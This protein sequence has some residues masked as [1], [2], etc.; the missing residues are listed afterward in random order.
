MSYEFNGL[1][2]SV[3]PNVYINRITLEQLNSQPLSNNKYDQAPHI[4]Q[5][6]TVLATAETNIPGYGAAQVAD[7]P[8]LL[9]TYGSYEDVLKVTFDLFL[10]IPS[11]DSDDFWSFLFDDDITKHLSINLLLFS[12][13]A[14]KDYYKK[15]MSGRTTYDYPSVVTVV[16]NLDA[17]V[18]D[19]WN[20]K[21]E[22]DFEYKSEKSI[23]THLMQPGKFLDGP[24]WDASQKLA[25]IR[26][27]Y[28]KTLPDGTVVYKIPIRMEAQLNGTSPAHLAAIAY[29]GFDATQLLSDETGAWNSGEALVP[30]NPAQAVGQK[31][32]TKTHGRMA[33][34]VIIQN[35]K[36][37]D[38]GMIFFVSNDQS[39]YD[40]PEL[41]ATRDAMFNHLKGQLWF[42]NVRKPDK[43]V[44]DQTYNKTLKYLAGQSHVSDEEQ[45][46]GLVYNRPQPFLDYIVVPNHRIQDFRQTI[47]M[48][49]MANFNPAIESI[50]GGSY[51]DSRSTTKVAGLDRPAIFSNLISSIDNLNHIKLFFSIDWGKLIRKHCAVPALIDKLSFNPSELSTVFDMSPKPISFKVFRERVDV[52][53]SIVNDGGRKL[54]YD[55]YPN[56][57]FHVGEQNQTGD[58]PSTYAGGKWWPDVV[59]SSLTPVKINSGFNGRIKHYSFTDYDIKRTTKGKFK[60]SIEFELYDPT[61]YYLQDQL[62][63]IQIALSLLKKYMYLANGTHGNQLYYN[64]HLGYFEEGFKTLA[65]PGTPEIEGLGFTNGV[66]P[67]SISD[68]IGT[69]KFMTQVM[70]SK[71]SSKPSQLPVWDVTIKNMLNPD[72]ATPDSITTVYE[73][74]STIALQLKSFIQSFAIAKI[75]KAAT[76]KHVNEDGTTSPIMKSFTKVPTGPSIP[77]R[78]ITVE[79]TFDG[80]PEIVDT[81]KMTAAYDFFGDVK[82]LS[83]YNVG[84]KV[85]PIVG[86]GSGSSYEKKSISQ[87]SNYFLENELPGDADNIEKKAF[88]IPFE[89]GLNNTQHNIL[90]S[91]KET[92]GRFFTVSLNHTYLPKTIGTSMWWDKTLN[93]IIRYK[94]DLFGDPGDNSYLGYFESTQFPDIHLV[95]SEMKGILNAYQSLAHK[96]AVFDHEQWASPEDPLMLGGESGPNDEPLPPNAQDEQELD[97]DQGQHVPWAS[98][99]GQLRFLSA[100]VAQGYFNLGF[101]DIKLGTFNAD[102]SKSSIGVYLNSFVP[103]DASPTAK[104]TWQWPVTK[105]LNELP[106]QI[107]VLMANHVAPLHAAINK[108]VHYTQMY[109]QDLYDITPEN[110]NDETMFA[111]K[112]SDFWFGHQN[113]VQIEFLSGYAHVEPGKGATSYETAFNS[114]VKIP[115][116]KPLSLER[117][118]Q[119]NNV[120]DGLLMCRLKKYKNPIF[121]QKVYD[122]LDLPI[123]DEYF[124]L[125]PSDFELDAQGTSISPHQAVHSATTYPFKETA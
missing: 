114:S 88:S 35:K 93:N 107:K 64:S 70:R 100:L 28:S 31:H 24:G 121:N 56:I 79:Y 48:K 86:H 82:N 66:L 81:T 58:L 65:G 119:L 34:E 25:Y 55:K 11:I 76:A 33:T 18:T 26:Q 123:Y 89:L 20:L 77:Q 43:T 94:Y 91:I 87:T 60:Y 5:S 29:C 83:E 53:N 99:F 63:S 110:T 47:I 23:F 105:A 92:Q 113:L 6:T 117:A 103:P 9:P 4:D 46:D 80:G 49:Q 21:K 101:K 16:S 115:S 72:T 59:L 104:N 116:W 84:L 27:K 57:Y 96:G 17:G 36:L 1:L 73:M 97:S 61:L 120:S 68:V 13:A 51:I 2:D 122:I 10:E 108:K 74:F 45:G 7:V 98:N 102:I 78:K 44:V 85:I 30:G 14:G 52:S 15:L 3:L 106:N 42:G 8:S 71:S 69:L 39:V 75:P 32:L 95:N 38:T 62:K 67:S 109:L 12:G 111:S 40:N 41:S 118:K 54:I 37:Q 90:T 112:F 124:F 50:F 125:K 22:I 19:F